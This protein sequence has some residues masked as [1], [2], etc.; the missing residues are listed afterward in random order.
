MKPGVY[1]HHKGK[2]YRVFFVAKHS[3]TLEDVVVYQALYG[4][5]AYWVRPL[6]MFIETIEIGGAQ[7]KR[8]ELVEEQ[9]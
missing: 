1:R 7:V 3:E 8:F 5:Y 6:A 4:D 2:L 9:K